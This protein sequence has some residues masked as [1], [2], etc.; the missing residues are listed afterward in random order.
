MKNRRQWQQRLSPGPLESRAKA[1]VQDLGFNSDGNDTHEQRHA[2]PSDVFALDTANSQTKRRRTTAAK[3]C[4]RP[5]LAESVVCALAV[6]VAVWCFVLAN[7]LNSFVPFYEE[8][9]RLLYQNFSKE[10]DL[11]RASVDK[12]RRARYAAIQSVMERRYV[13]RHK[14]NQRIEQEQQRCQREVDE[15][16]QEAGQG[17]DSSV[18]NMV[19]AWLGPGNSDSTSGT[20]SSGSGD[21]GD[22]ANGSTN[23]NEQNNYDTPH[24]GDMSATMRRTYLSIC[25]P[26][27][28]R[29]FRT[30]NVDYLSP[31]LDLL[32]DQLW[33]FDVKNFRLVE[34]GFEMSKLDSSLFRVAVYDTSGPSKTHVAFDGAASLF[35]NS[36]VVEEG[37]L[38]F[39]RQNLPFAEDTQFE[40]DDTVNKQGLPGH[41]VRKQTWDVLN[42][43]DHCS[44]R[45]EFTM[46]VEDDF[47][48]CP[49]AFATIAKALQ[50]AKECRPRS[51]WQT[52]T[53]SFGLNGIVIQSKMVPFLKSFFLEKIQLMPPDWLIFEKWFPGKT[54]RLEFRRNLFVHVGE[55]SSFQFRN[56]ADFERRVDLPECNA[57][58]DY[59]HEKKVPVNED[60]HPCEPGT[61]AASFSNKF[62]KYRTMVMRANKVALD[63]MKAE[64]V[65][66]KQVSSA[67]DA[68]CGCAGVESHASIQLTSF[69][70]PSPCAKVQDFRSGCKGGRH[71]A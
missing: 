38:R 61:S 47:F 49:G 28:P 21:G 66:L 36:S 65:A 55:L 37:A 35:A 59:F 53:F 60:L 44:Q 34:N 4:L 5:S 40:P 3:S 31:T 9:G 62:A 32:S 50:N 18:G 43:L 52:L 19:R 68:Q 67:N 54:S 15:L 20:S 71:D 26:S 69:R 11:V 7:M 39:I 13:D 24:V 51:D 16:R 33:G 8:K 57:E 25:M 12:E 42:I 23:S 27:H 41:S 63:K 2:R 14:C 64:Y 6:L 46:I 29:K 58:N 70:T 22:K 1:A 48:P 17:S 10:V 30:K 56:D 45:S